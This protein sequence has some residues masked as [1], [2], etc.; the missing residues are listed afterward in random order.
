[1][2]SGGLWWVLVGFSALALVDVG[3]LRGGGK[4]WGRVVDRAAVPQTGEQICSSA[5]TWRPSHTRVQP[6]RHSQMETG[7]CFCDSAGRSRAPW[8]SALFGNRANAVSIHAKRQRRPS[9]VLMTVKHGAPALANSFFITFPPC[10]HVLDHDREH[11]SFS[12]FSA[13]FFG[14][15]RRIFLNLKVQFRPVSARSSPEPAPAQSG[16]GTAVA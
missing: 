7:V 2:S 5:F 15:W 13:V 10:D 6:V 14:F 8:I 1:M 12:F 9:L 4:W 3:L 11:F 16:F